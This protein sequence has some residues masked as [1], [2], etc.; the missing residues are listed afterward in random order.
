[1]LLLLKTPVKKQNKMKKLLTILLL[2]LSTISYADGWRHGGGHYVY[3]PGYGWIVPAVVG[4]VIVYGVTR[5]RP[6]EVVYIPEPVSP[7]PT[8]PYWRT[9]AD[10]HW[11]AV[12]DA[13]CNCYRTVLV[14]NQ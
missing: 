4:G 10:M 9:P 13:N 3:R 8:T 5:P 14:P 11:E 12:L 1:M 2:S 7:P 6:P